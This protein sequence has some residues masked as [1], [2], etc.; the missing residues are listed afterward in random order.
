MAG[1]YRQRFVNTPTEVAES[2][3][4]TVPF[5]IGRFWSAQERPAA[6]KPS[7]DYSINL[8][9]A[10]PYRRRTRGRSVLA[11]AGQALLFNQGQL[12]STTPLLEEDT[13]GIYLRIHPSLIPELLEASEIT[14]A[15]RPRLPAVGPRLTQAQVRGWYSLWR[16]ACAGMTPDALYE[17]ALALCLDLLSVAQGPPRP[18]PRIRRRVEA[19]QLHICQDPASSDTLDTLADGVGWSRF[20]LCRWFRAQTGVTVHRYREDLRM[21]RAIEGLLEPTV[22]LTELA[23]S[24]GYTSHSHFSDRFR[25]RMG[26]PPGRFRAHI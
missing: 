21:A 8:L 19:I 14:P 20:Q 10:G 7:E 9:T 25:R 26:E 18:P 6:P 5:S 1:R 22:D 16:D 17:R 4:W 13:R 24:L 11:D 2:M 3:L 15:P 23:L 12:Y